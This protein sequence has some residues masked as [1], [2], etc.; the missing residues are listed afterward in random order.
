MQIT[1]IR[2][3][4]YDKE[5]GKLTDEGIEQMTCSAMV[6]QDISDKQKGVLR[7]EPFHPDK[8]DRS[9]I[10]PQLTYSDFSF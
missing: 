7:R 3:G 2:H 5:T 4:E 8:E 1:F 9:I 6:L 10:V